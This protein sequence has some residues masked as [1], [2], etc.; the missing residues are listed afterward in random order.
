MIYD[1]LTP[2]YPAI[3]IYS[4]IYA[5]PIPWISDKQY[6]PYGNVYA[7]YL[8]RY[9]LFMIAKTKVRMSGMQ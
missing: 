4:C 7:I 1:I 6:L 9:T 5:F 3:L 8:W 2:C